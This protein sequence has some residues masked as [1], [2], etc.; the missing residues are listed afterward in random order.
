MAHDGCYSSGDAAEQITQRMGIEMPT[1][2]LLYLVDRG[3]V[4][5][6]S[7]MVRGRRLFS[8]SDIDAV[9][10][11]IRHRKQNVKAHKSDSPLL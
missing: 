10:D 11:A 1:W 3:Y 2:R 4:P 7:R 6:P 5:R 9:C 8:A